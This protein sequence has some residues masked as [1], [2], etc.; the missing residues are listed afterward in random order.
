M[1][2]QRAYVEITNMCN[3]NCSFCPG[4]TR[5]PG[6]MEP[7]A[8]RRMAE[9]LRPYTDYLCLHIMGEPLLHPRLA[10]LLEIAGELGFRVILTTNGTLLAQCGKLLLSSPAL[11]KVQ[12]SLQS[13]EANGAGDMETYLADCCAFAQQAAEAG[14]LCTL[15]LWNLDGRETAGQNR[16]NGQVLSRIETLLPGSWVKNTRGYRLRDRLF[17]EWGETFAWPEPDREEKSPQRTCYGLRR[18][19]G[20][21]WDGT[22]VPCCLDSNGTLAL[23]NLLEESLEDILQKPRARAMVEGF[24]R[25]EAVE[26]LCRRC[27][28]AERFS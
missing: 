17:L 8:F 12:I 10:L 3:R 18:Q 9:K 6:W 21:L 13:F 23:G 19:I 24:E 27:G 16:L 25:H 2:F 28:F 14:I 20:V 15:R 1:R 22:V 5:A 11:H 4:T 7:E 26:P